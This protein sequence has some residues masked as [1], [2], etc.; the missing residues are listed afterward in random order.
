MSYKIFIPSYKRSHLMLDKNRRTTPTFMSKKKRENSTIVIRK[1]DK[2]FYEEVLEKR[3]PELNLHVLSENAKNIPT[4]RDEILKTASMLKIQYLIMIDDDIIFAYKPDPKTYVTFEEKH[5]DWM[6]DDL[7]FHCSE[8]YP[9]IG[10]TARQFSNN[11][12]NPSDENTRIIQVYCI[13]I[14]TWER[15]QI[16]FE[17]EEMEFA[18]D[19]KFILEWLAR[20]YKNLCLNTYTRD[21]IAQM[22]GGC[23]T[24]RTA[25][26]HSQS[27]K[28]LYKMFPEV[29]SLRW[30]NNGTWKEPR[31][32]CMVQWKK[33]YDLYSR[34]SDNGK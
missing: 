4:T 26:L 15:E 22:E 24:Y 20:G 6:V 27:M 28:V 25:D 7:L 8:E 23:E 33:A 34:R 21:D 14:P 10:I 2:V 18:T 9:I 30:K 11:K 5:F 19:Y 3:W 31:L 17:T 32:N 13:H 16:Y 29:V 12:V 1:E